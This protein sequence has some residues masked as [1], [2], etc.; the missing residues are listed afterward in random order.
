MNRHKVL[1]WI[2]AIGLLAWTLLALMVAEGRG[3]N[4]ISKVELCYRPQ[5]VRTTRRIYDQATDTHIQFVPTNGQCIPLN[6]PN[7]S[8]RMYVRLQWR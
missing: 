1:G 5:D 4:M 8:G 2:L 6:F 3:Q 7:E